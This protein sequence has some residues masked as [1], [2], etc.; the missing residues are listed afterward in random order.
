MLPFP[1]LRLLVSPTAAAGIHLVA[2]VAYMCSSAIGTFGAATLLALHDINCSLA[3]GA[4]NA[5]VVGLAATVA[6]SAPEATIS[7]VCGFWRCCC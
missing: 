2:A 1:V 7:V 4:Y 3:V 5:A 6:A